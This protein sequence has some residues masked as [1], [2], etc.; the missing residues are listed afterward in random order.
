MAKLQFRKLT[1]NKDGCGKRIQGIDDAKGTKVPKR[2]IIWLRRRLLAP[3]QAK[4]VPGRL[5][6]LGFRLRLAG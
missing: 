2:R 1:R 5:Q 3:G 4:K 6:E